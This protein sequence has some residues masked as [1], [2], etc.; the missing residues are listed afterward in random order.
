MIMGVRLK[1]FL[2]ALFLFGVGFLSP[3][4]SGL[5]FIPLYYLFLHEE[6]PALFLFVLFF[7]VLMD[8]GEGVFP[9]N[10]LLTPAVFAL[11]MFQR[12]LPYEQDRLFFSS[13]FLLMTLFFFVS[14]TIL[15]R[16]FFEIGF[17]WN[18]VLN[19]LCLLF[20]YFVIE[21]VLSFLKIRQEKM[22]RARR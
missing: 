16:S 7:S 8:V 12:F 4:L 10:T 1:T 14:K 17:S 20:I 15:L 2:F 22:I 6:R 21:L 11:F 5:F 13:G 19:F 9:V 3:L 18:I